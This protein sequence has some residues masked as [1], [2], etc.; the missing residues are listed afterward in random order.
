[1]RFT[2]EYLDPTGLYHLRA[3]QYDQT[4]G[5]FLNPDPLDTATSAPSASAYAY[6]GNRPVA[7]TDP[8]GMI[9]TSSTEGTDTTNA[10]SSVELYST[11]APCRTAYGSGFRG[12][13]GFGGTPEVD[14]PGRSLLSAG[15]AATSGSVEFR[16]NVIVSSRR[17]CERTVISWTRSVAFEGGISHLNSRFEILFSSRRYPYT[18]RVK[19]SDSDRSIPNSYPNGQE[20][21]FKG[22][23]ERFGVPLR[24]WTPTRLTM[25]I[26]AQGFANAGAPFPLLA[27]AYTMR[28]PFTKTYTEPAA[29]PRSGGGGSGCSWSTRG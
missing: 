16:M 10:A 23:D 29:T 17:D 12:H 4:I 3:R 27:P 24:S 22:E 2:G 5:R 7:L 18:R 20:N 26:S 28:C 8:S 25:T 11:A 9:Q 19:P 21:E 6:V 1:M 14:L 13:F 15:A